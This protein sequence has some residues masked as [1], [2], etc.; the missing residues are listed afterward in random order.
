MKQ[1]I[2]VEISVYVGAEK[3]LM[4]AYHTWDAETDPVSAD[5]TAK[6]LLAHLTH[7]MDSALDPCFFDHDEVLNGTKN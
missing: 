4:N 5:E 7:K 2:K 1:T 3:Y 6:D